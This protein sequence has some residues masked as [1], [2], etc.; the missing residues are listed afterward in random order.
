[1]KTEMK[2]GAP[3]KN[4]MGNMAVGP[5]RPMV[6]AIIALLAILAVMF[7]KS[8]EPGY[9]LFSNDGPLGAMMQELN[10]MPSALKGLWL[11]LNWLG[12]ENIAPPASISSLLRLGTSPY[13][14]E[15]ILCPT[16]ILMAGLGACFCFRRLKLSPWACVLGAL[17]AALNSDFFSTSCWGVSTQVIGF[18]AMFAAIGFLAEPQAKWSWIRVVLAGMAV[19]VGVME[20]YDIGALFSLFVAA[21]VVYQT[22]FLTG[23]VETV[24]V[25]IGRSAVRGFMV[26]MCAGLI[27]THTLTGLVG[28][29][30]KGIAGAEQDEQVKAMEWAQKTQ[31]SVPKIEI[32]QVVVPGIFGYRQI[33]HMYESDQP[34]ENQYW[35]TI[36]MGGGLSRLVGTGFYAGV[37]VVMIAL[38]AVLQSFRTR[39]SPFTI[40]Q[41]R[42]IWFWTVALVVAA[43]L[44]FGKNAPFYQFFYLL[45]YT[46][47]I[48]NPQKFMHVF[49]WALVIVFAY[50]VHGLSVAYMQKP[51]AGAEG[52]FAQFKAWKAKAQPFERWW[53]N[54][55]VIAIV[56]SVLGWLIYATSGSRL[57][58]YLETVGI[59]PE[60]AP[61]IAQFSI[62]ALG[63][64]VVL[65]VLA[66]GLMALI[67]SGQFTGSRARWGGIL[68]ALFLVADL[69]R[70]DAPWIVYW[71]VGY[72]YASDPVI[73]FLAEKPYEQRISLLPMPFTEDIIKRLSANQPERYNGWMQQLGLLQNAYY[74]AWKQ[75]LFPYHNIQSIDDIQEPRMGVDKRALQMA[76]PLNSGANFLRWWEL[77]N[78]RYI[79]GPGPEVVKQLDP[80]GKK[81]RSILS[82]DLKPK[83][84]NPSSWTEDW[85][86]V[87]NPNG[88]LSVIEF[89]DALPRAK[90]YSQWQVSTNDDATL[91]EVGSPA[92]DPQ[93]T[94]L[95]S[96][97]IAPPNPANAG[98]DP[99][100]AT[101]NPNYRSKRVEVQ[102]DVKV[103]SILLLVERYNDNWH[104][105]VDGKAA[106]ILRCNFITRGIYLEPGKHTVVMRYQPSTSTLWMSLAVI[107][108]GLILWGFV[109][110][111]RPD[112][113]IPPAATPRKDEAKK[114]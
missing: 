23:A 98:K 54:G 97:P 12:S 7:H 78:T 45:P 33:W 11:D 94:V 90:L 47:T 53:F 112:M 79:L 56:V 109:A 39:G 77:S 114:A 103:P 85:I 3:S 64:F 104:A 18:G 42:A 38:W 80:T 57:R 31:W 107:T 81:L 93:Q 40:L 67:C 27:A 1:M 30:I 35:G 15:K 71:D 25:K 41:R 20:A 75:N 66:I 89:T 76:L 87:E 43:L 110:L 16:A 92:F 69:G 91:Q 100:T 105:E 29:Q 63:W 9:V 28:T 48:R 74:S 6:W 8:L 86:S 37:L 50:G 36:G 34:K 88:Q 83:K 84:P 65:L 106:T 95:V 102:A 82:F 21:F 55:S 68:L 70:A 72:K 14:Y 5:K 59:N 2:P 101:V 24:P 10:R 26:A 22:L 108:A 58:A 32:L 61:G 73:N 17:A 99:G 60:E 96:D 13:V 49:S 51:V 113:E 46:S 44:A 4:G 19:G 52:W 62:H 111:I